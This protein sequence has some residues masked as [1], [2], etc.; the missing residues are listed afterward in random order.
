MGSAT[1]LAGKFTITIKLNALVQF[2]HLDYQLVTALGAGLSAICFLALPTTG[3]AA[4]GQISKKPFG[5][6][7][8]GTPVDLYTLRNRHGMEVKICNYGGIVVSISVP[9]KHG[10]FAVVTL[11]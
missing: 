5:S 6:L 1:I 3:A 2:M 8:D 4:S 11:G 9:D 10:E 7:P